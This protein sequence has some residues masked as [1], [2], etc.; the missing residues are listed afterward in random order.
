MNSVQANWEAMDSNDSYELNVPNL[1]SENGFE[2][3]LFQNNKKQFD[4]FLTNNPNVL[5]NYTTQNEF[6][7]SYRSN[8]LAYTITIHTETEVTNRI[9]NER[10]AFHEADC[11]AINKSILDKQFLPYCCI[12]VD[13]LVKQWYKWLYK[14]MEETVPRV[15]SHRKNLPLGSLVV[16]HTKQKLFPH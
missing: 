6:N 2:E 14:I 5:L 7:R 10:F 13:E 1:L 12:D 16:H 9:Q 11:N 8:H 3:C 15:T 4:V